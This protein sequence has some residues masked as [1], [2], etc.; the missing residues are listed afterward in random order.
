MSFEI[1]QNESKS[2]RRLS[3]SSV[4][5]LGSV[6]ET[7][8]VNV[9]SPQPPTA[10]RPLAGTE[11]ALSSSRSRT[12]IS[13]KRKS[14]ERQPQLTRAPSTTKENT[15]SSSNSNIGSNNSKVN[16]NV[17][18]NSTKTVGVAQPARQGYMGSLSPEEEQ[19][20]REVRRGA[21]WVL[22]VCGRCNRVRFRCLIWWIGI[23]EAPFPRKNL[24]N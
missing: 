12:A 7:P 23:T 17:P 18:Q 24:H 2:S 20:L 14:L 13:E 16:A 22:G 4:K 6:S 11:G 19:E 5:S 8:S 3:G 1:K 15:L 9:R 21:D 10:P